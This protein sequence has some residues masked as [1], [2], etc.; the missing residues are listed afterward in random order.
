MLIARKDFS[1]PLGV[2]QIKTFT[3]ILHKN[4]NPDKYKCVLDVI[5][6]HLLSIY[7]KAKA[8]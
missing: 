1:N 4:I 6:L 5:K 8:N 2:N 3:S 7:V